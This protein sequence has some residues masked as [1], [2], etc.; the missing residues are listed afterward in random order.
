M[1]HWF[2][3]ILAAFIGIFL[4]MLDGAF[5]AGL[6]YPFRFVDLVFFAALYCLIVLQERFGVVLFISGSMAAG[7][8]YNQDVFVPAIVGS[9]VL[10]IISRALE[11]LFTNRTYYSVMAV[12][13]FGWML[14]IGGVVGV[15]SIVNLLSETHSFMPPTGS[16]LLVAMVSMMISA[17]LAYAGTVIF[18]KKI[19]SYFIV[20]GRA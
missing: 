12:A 18:S 19:R 13:I 2:F 6:A 20:G 17:T 1:R 11:R 9:L 7:L 10:F 14:Y 4:A 16:E 15:Y 8:T 5:I 3:L